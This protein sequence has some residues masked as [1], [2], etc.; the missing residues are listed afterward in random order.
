MLMAKNVGKSYKSKS[1]QFLV[2]GFFV[3]KKVV[4]KVR[5]ELTRSHPH[6]FLSLVQV[7]LI[8]VIRRDLVQPT[9][10]CSLSARA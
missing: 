4:P 1:P 2:G 9:E 8:S 7:V 10:Y 3:V 5:V 6:W